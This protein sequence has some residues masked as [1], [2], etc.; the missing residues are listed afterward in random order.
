M[1]IFQ[2]G[3]LLHPETFDELSD[4]DIALTHVRS[5]EEYFQIQGA[6]MKMTEF[7]LDCIEL[8]KVSPENRDLLLLKGKWIHEPA[9]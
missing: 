3:S 4:V 7:P 1:G 5:P 6:L 9:E 2:W 8:D